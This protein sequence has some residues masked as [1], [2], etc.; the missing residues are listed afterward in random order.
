MRLKA[1]KVI[2]GPQRVVLSQLHNRIRFFSRLRVLETHR[3]HRTVAERIFAP[4]RHNLDRHAAFKDVLV[5][6]AV[7]RRFLRGFQR[8]DKGDVLVLLHC[9]VNII[10]VS[11]VIARSKPR[12]VHVDGIE[13]NERRGSV[14]KAHVLLTAEVCLDCCAHGIAGQRSR[15]NNHRSLRHL[16]NFLFHDRNVRVIADFLRHKPGKTIPVD[17]KRAACFYPVRLRAGKNQTSEPA[18]LLFQKPDCVFQ[19]VAAQGV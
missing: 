13:G 15:S 18:Q 3:L 1:D 5:L 17:G 9:A 6:K 16:R 10:R 7:N 2:D 4:A 8:F 19:P 12:L 11:P 14:E